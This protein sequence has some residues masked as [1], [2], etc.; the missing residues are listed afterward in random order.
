MPPASRISR[1]AILFGAIIR[2]LRLE[3]G[4]TMVKF[5][6]RA[7]MHVNYL[8]IVERGGNIPSLVT[9]LELADVFGVDPGE[10]IR[11]VAEGRKPK[12]VAPPPE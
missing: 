8:R 1:D 6:R 5:A 12:P 2:R 9:I 3:R 10:V 7:G 11:Q 4:W